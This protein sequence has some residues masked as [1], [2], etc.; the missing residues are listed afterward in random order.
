MYFLKLIQ[1]FSRFHLIPH[2]PTPSRHT[3]VPRIPPPPPPWTLPVWGGCWDGG[4]RPSGAC[5]EGPHFRRV[6]RSWCSA[7]KAYTGTGGHYPTSFAPP[8]AAGTLTAPCSFPG[9]G[10]GLLAPGPPPV[11]L[12]KPV[13]LPVPKA[14]G[15]ACPPPAIYSHLSVT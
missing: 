13:L 14:S 6:V 3:T 2:S 4:L 11:Q 1:H 5:A 8:H 9:P 7:Q 10:L 12:L 15:A